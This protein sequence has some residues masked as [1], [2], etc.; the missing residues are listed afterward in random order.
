MSQIPTLQ[1]R[2]DLEDHVLVLSG[3]RVASFAI[4][5]DSDPHQFLERVPSLFTSKYGP[6]PL[7]EDPW[8]TA[9]LVLQGRQVEVMYFI[10]D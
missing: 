7:L 6:S 1:Q 4:P 9:V 10:A 3:S 2:S 8:R 5:P